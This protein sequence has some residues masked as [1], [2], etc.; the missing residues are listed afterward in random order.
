MPSRGKV[1]L[2]FLNK[3]I[4]Q[5]KYFGAGLISHFAMTQS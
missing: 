2:H 5:L 1:T 4:K 3:S